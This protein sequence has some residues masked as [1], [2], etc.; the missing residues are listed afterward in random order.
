[1]RYVALVH[2]A[3]EQDVGQGADREHRH[4][5]APVRRPGAG[6]SRGLQPK[7][8]IRTFRVERLYRLKRRREANFDNFRNYDRPCFSNHREVF[9]ARKRFASFDSFRP[10]YDPCA[11]RREGGTRGKE[12]KEKLV[13]ESW[14][15]GGNGRRTPRPTPAIGV[16][17]VRI[18]EREEARLLKI[19]R[20]SS[21]KRKEQPSQLERFYRAAL[22]V[23]SSPKAARY[24]SSRIEI[25]TRQT[26]PRKEGRGRGKD[27]SCSPLR[28]LDLDPRA[29]E[30]TLFTR[31]TKPPTFLSDTREGQ[32]DRGGT[33]GSD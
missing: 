25:D 31:L 4:V 33:R 11:A 17:R 3:G 18:P 12:R 13:G 29:F 30:G 19:F 28:S 14:Y 16:K 9:H 2:A 26:F 20:A 15:L 8:N 27:A 1:M 6:N 5:L 21:S 7:T 24:A 10:V 32:F 23:S 22:K